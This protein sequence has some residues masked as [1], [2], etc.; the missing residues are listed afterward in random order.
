MYV[1]KFPIRPV[2]EDP[3]NSSGG[4]WILRLKK[5]LADRYWEE[6]VLALVGETFFGGL[7]PLDEAEREKWRAKRRAKSISGSGSSDAL[8][9]LPDS[10]ESEVDGEDDV[11]EENECEE[12][13]GV[14]LSVRKDEDI[15]SVWNRD[16]SEAGRKIRERIR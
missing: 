5:G 15:L 11:I 9:R 1:S 16:A 4:K 12:I 13:C 3:H 7:P 10:W 2:W 14:V 8:A 6:I